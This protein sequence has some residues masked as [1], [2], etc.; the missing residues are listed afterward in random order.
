M[1]HLDKPQGVR[2]LFHGVV[3]EGRVELHVLLFPRGG[4]LQGERRERVRER[5]REGGRERGREGE[6]EGGRE[7]EREGWRKKGEGKGERGSHRMVE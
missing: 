5:G 3:V 4:W 2:P 7:G 6:R 1:A